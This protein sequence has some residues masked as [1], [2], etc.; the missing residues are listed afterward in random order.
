LYYAHFI[1]VDK[2]N[3]QR[4]FKYTVER[5]SYPNGK[6]EVLL[7]DAI[8]PRLSRDGK[9]LAYLSFDLK[10]S[11]N[12]LFIGDLDG[13]NS[14]AQIK[15]GTFIAVDAH[16]FS[17][18][19]KTILFSAVGEGKASLLNLFDILMGVG[20]AQAHDVPS[21]WWTLEVASG[22]LTRLTRIYDVGLYGSFSPDG[23]HIAFIAASGVYVMKADGNNLT[24]ITSV[25]AVGTLEWVP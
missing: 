23:K 3:G 20:I 12:D 17:P 18:D 7:E 9:R 24:P 5:L 16:H 2:G 19:D 25:S 22:K 21:D 8:W 14:K 6:P 11:S 10:T 15:P 1:P 4:G 13:K